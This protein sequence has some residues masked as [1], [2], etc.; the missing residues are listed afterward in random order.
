MICNSCKNEFHNING[1]KFCPYCGT[2]IEEPI[3][4]EAEQILEKEF[5]EKEKDTEEATGEMK[6][7]HNTLKMPIITEEEVTRYKKIQFFNS[8][9]KPFTNMKIVIPI[10]TILIII[11]VGIFGYSFLIAKPVDEVR[12]KDDLTGKIVMLPKGTSVE[13]KKGYIKSLSVNNRNTNKSEKKDDITVSVILNNG[14]VEVKTLLSLQYVYEG[15][16]TW[17]IAE[18]IQLEGDATIKPVVA[19]DETQLL[20]GLKKLN[21]TIGDTEKALSADYVK[22]LNITSRTPDLENLKEEVLVQANIDN[23]LMAATGKIKCKLNFEN[24]AWIIASIEKNSVEDFTLE[25]SP[26]FSQEKILEFVKKDVIEETLTH[27]SVFGGKG[28]YVK[29][30]FTKSINLG[31]K[32]FDAQSGKLTVTAK[33]ENV[34]GE[35]KST[36]STDYTFSLTFSKIELLK[37]SKTTLDSVSIADMSKDFIVATISNIEIE[38]GNLFFLFS[39]NHKI[40]A[41]EAKTFKTDKVLFKKG[42]QNVKYVFGSLTYIDGKKQ[43]TISLVATYFL[44]YDTSKGYSWKLDKIVGEDSPIYKSYTSELQ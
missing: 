6:K 25:L 18:K 35:M 13:I 11:G 8:L 31:D 4:L 42:F 43:K 21:I 38:G 1:L 16:N 17:K 28:F 29:D 7:I 34:A 9:K 14:T 3:S 20:A 22:T 2:E 44:V 32:N 40:T 26:S 15:K 23:G 10:L 19:M 12:I 27:S 5:S 30:S 41:E 36:L 39:D 33:R 37:K 24:E